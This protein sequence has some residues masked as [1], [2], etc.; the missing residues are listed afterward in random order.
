MS[1]NF[2]GLTGPQGVLP[3][4]YTNLVAERARAKDHAV[5][6]FLDI[7]NHRAAALFYAA[8]ERHRFD[9]AFERDERDRLSH[10]LSAFIGLAT[11]GLQ[12]RMSVPDHALLYYSGLLSLQ[13]RS[14]SALESI[15]ADFFNVPV[16]VTDFVGGWQP[17]RP[18]D[19]TSV[20]ED[21]ETAQLGH[22]AIAGDAVWDEQSR[23]MISL[24]PL[25]RARYS[26]FLPDGCDWLPLRSLVL[27]FC[28][29][30]M[31][32]D[33]ELSML[34]EQVPQCELVAPEPQAPRLGWTSWLKSKPEF[35]R[36]PQ[37]T[38]LRLI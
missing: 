15:V 34:C 30:E 17:L 6:D 2:M 9:V 16:T 23:V 29:P 12:D 27:F 25:S 8:W 18:A 3:H 19:R 28:G 20:D 4:C 14:V 35:D 38:I 11:N 5:G 36:N 37:D 22:S 32:V 26:D 7:F 24:G 1:V 10:Y 13:S 33:V 31:Q 21:S